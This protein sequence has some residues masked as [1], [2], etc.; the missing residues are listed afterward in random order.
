MHIKPLTEPAHENS[1]SLF[2]ES[3]FKTKILVWAICFYRF[4]N[5]SYPASV[6]LKIR[7]FKTPKLLPFTADIMKVGSYIYVQCFSLMMFLI[8]VY[9]VR[10]MLLWL[11]YSNRSVIG[12]ILWNL[13]T[14]AFW[15]ESGLYESTTRSTE[16]LTK[17]KK[18]FSTCSKNLR[19]SI[20]ELNL[21]S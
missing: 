20:K 12:K 1:E 15:W 11:F 3:Y 16:I 14:H 18:V 21:L 17:F 2:H 7:R 6:Q 9:N 5:V 13:Q 19:K 4:D 8:I 10:V